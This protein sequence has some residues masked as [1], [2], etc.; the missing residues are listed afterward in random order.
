[1][2]FF[3]APAPGENQ[4]GGYPHLN[5]PPSNGGRKTN[6]FTKLAL[7]LSLL[8]IF[9]PRL[10]LQH[11]LT[12]QLF[13]GFLAVAHYIAQYRLRVPAQDG[14]LPTARESGVG[15]LQ[16]K[17]RQHDAAEAWIFHGDN[18]TPLLEMRIVR[19]ILAGLYDAAGHAGSLQPIHDFKRVL[20]PRPARD[21]RVKLVAMLE[22]AA[23]GPETSDLD[24]SRHR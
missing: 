15:E 1:M 2:P 19:Q 16:R 13:D 17:V 8:E 4:R 9:T 20:V 7:Q 23:G 24:Q 14:E 22:P 3:F 18:E 11:S 12:P 21:G 10:L 5:L 6:S